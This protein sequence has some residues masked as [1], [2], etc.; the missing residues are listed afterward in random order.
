LLYDI[1]TVVQDCQSALDGTASRIKDELLGGSAWRPYFPLVTDPTDFDL[2]LEGQLPGLAADHPRVADAFRRHQPFQPGKS[3]LGYLHKLA[4]ANKHSDFSEQ[5]RT[6][7]LEL[8]PESG[9]GIIGTP[10]AYIRMGGDSSIRVGPGSSISFGDGPVTSHGITRTVLVGW[11][12]ADPAV[13]VLPTLKALV[14]LTRGAV[15]DVFLSA[16]L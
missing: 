7:A 8:K 4:R 16:S 10:G 6:E 1:R 13:P 14:A 2:K 11:N 5:I 15:S 9:G 3:E 12:F